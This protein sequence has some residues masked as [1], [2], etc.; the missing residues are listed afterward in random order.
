MISPARIGHQLGRYA[1]LWLAAFGL[2]GAGVLTALI[3][4][5]LIDATDRVVPPLL[6]ALAL[7]YLAGVSTALMARQSVMTRLILLVLATLLLLPLLWAPVSAAVAIAFLAGQVIDYSRAYAAFQLGVG[8][9][10]FPISRH[11]GDG[12]LLGSA[13]SG[14]QIFAS[15]VGLV[16]LLAQFRRRRAHAVTQTGTG[17]EKP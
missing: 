10:L 17:Q 2:G 3:F 11:W 16:C 14:F 13:W 4:T 5:D 7:V 8:Q 9:L 15:V 1:V 12:D 6:V